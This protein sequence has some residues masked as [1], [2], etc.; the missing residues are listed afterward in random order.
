MCSPDP[1]Y[2]AA[3]DGLGRSL[4]ARDV[5]LVYGGA[6]VGLMGVVADAALAAGGSVIG[7]LPRALSDLEI[8]HPGLTE[9]R[10]VETMHERKTMM[11]DTSDAFI[12]LPGGLGTL[13]ETFEVWTWSQLGVHAKPVGFLNVNGYFDRLLAF[14]DHAVAE[15]FVTS[16]HRRFACVSTSPDDLIT[17][18]A[19]TDTTYEPKWIDMPGR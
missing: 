11:A 18:L 7:V 5:T 13:E 10:V 12:A 9:L 17:A 6:S 1:G 19:A 14:L 2:A 15:G 8:G 3:A 16:R 4:A